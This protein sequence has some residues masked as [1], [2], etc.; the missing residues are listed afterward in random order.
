[1]AFLVFYD[2]LM[3]LIFI[4]VIDDYHVLC[5]FQFHIDFSAAGQK[6]SVCLSVC[7]CV[8]QVGTNHNCDM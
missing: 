3:S 4:I 1:V 8:N 2:D 7:V 5:L 6:L